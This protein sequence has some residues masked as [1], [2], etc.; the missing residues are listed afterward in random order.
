MNYSFINSDFNRFATYYSVY[1]SANIFACCDWNEM[2]KSIADHNCF[3]IK[4]GEDII[5][6]FTLT[7]NQLSHPFVIPLNFDETLFWYEVLKYA[8]SNSKQNEIV[9]KFIPKK[10]TTILV[11][12]F[13]AKLIY[14]QRRM[15]RPTNKTLPLLAEDYYFTELTDYDRA[16]I[17]QAIYEA[18]AMGYTA[19][20]KPPDKNE[21]QDAIN[22][23][24]DLFTKTYSLHFSTLVKKKDCDEIVGVCIA[25]IYP[26]SPN[27]F[28]TIHQVS[29]RPQFRRNGIAE[30]MILNTINKASS[31]S[32]VITLGV[33]V[34]NPAELLYDK[35]GFRRYP[36]YS[37]LYY[38]V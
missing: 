6:G 27:N 30:A 23:R 12:V 22:R 7:D 33:M 1:A 11:D 2:I 10:E 17:I 4:K 21:I 29:V 35:V 20:V 25:G 19:T 16:E 18:H 28:S 36:E 3:F 38:S 34:G 9:M 13:M 5:G 8:L 15:L 26:D 24:Y 37:E 32:P 31:V 14:T